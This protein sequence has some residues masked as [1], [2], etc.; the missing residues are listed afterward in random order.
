[1]WR[2]VRIAV[3]G[4]AQALALLILAGLLDGLSIED[5]ARALAVVVVLALLNALLWPL[6]VR[7]ALP[8]VLVTLGLFTFVLNAVFIWLASDAVGG[9]EVDSFWTAIAVSFLLTVVN[10]AVGG[11]LEID[12]DHAWRQRVVKRLV[13]R[14]ES[15]TP[16]EVPGFLFIQIDGLGHEVLADA[17][18]SGHAPFLARLVE[19]G[20]HVFHEWEC[21]L[22]SQT[23]AMQA[24]ILLGDNHNM[25]AFRWYEKDGDRVPRHEPSQ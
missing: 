5:F 1:M 25:P 17:M 7:I 4:L 2:P 3:L 10:I 9:V 6:V 21:D 19:S 20:T 22:S 23:G 12:N 13:R 18:S 11:M 14:T 15:V 24:G 8:L 16:T